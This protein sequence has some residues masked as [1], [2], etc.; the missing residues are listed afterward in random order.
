[1][2]RSSPSGRSPISPGVVIV[3][4]CLIGVTGF[5][6]R[7]IFGLFLTPMTAAFDWS[8]ETFSM[9]LAIQNLLWG[10]G[11]PLAG[12]LADRYGP[13]Y[14]LAG[15]SVVYALGIWGMANSSHILMLHLTAGVVVGLGVAFTAFSLAMVAIARAVGPER[16][17]LALGLGT[18]AGS[19]GQVVF[20]P[21]G[22]SFI[23]TLGWSTALGLLAIISLLIVPLAFFIPNTTRAKGEADSDQT[24]AEAVAEAGRHKGFRLLNVG[25]FACGF[26]IAF[27]TVHFPSYVQDLGFAAVVGA[28]SIALIGVFNIVGS[29]GSGAYGQRWSRKR[30]L[31]TLYALRGLLT[32]AMLMAPKTEPTIYLFAGGLGLLWLATVP[33]TSGI[34]EQVFGIR[35]LATLFGFVFLSHQLGSFIGVW[36]GGYVYDHTGSYD[37]MWI[38]AIAINLSAAVVHLPIDDRPVARL[39]SSR[40]EPADG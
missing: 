33:L 25:F 27:I 23:N 29:F 12:A 7:S 6:I 40:E 24:I 3:A 22:Q 19:V 4:G 34:V 1:M 2:A 31:S 8:R 38:I 39:G 20:S 28:V 10:L 36:L 21:L 9:A 15:G 18:A 32:A 16:R 13:R 35:Y 14:V 30:G 5:G 17:S 37:L 26:H 11:L